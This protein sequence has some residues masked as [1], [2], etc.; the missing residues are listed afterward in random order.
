MRVFEEFREFEDTPPHETVSLEEQAAERDAQ[1]MFQMNGLQLSWVE[2]L[3]RNLS[4][5]QIV[6]QAEEIADHTI[7]KE[8]QKRI[9]E[10]NLDV[11]KEAIMGEIIDP[12]G[13]PL[14]GP[15]RQWFRV[16]FPHHRDGAI[17]PVYKQILKLYSENPEEAVRQL[18]TLY[19]A[20]LH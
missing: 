12:Q 4:D 7:S 8:L 13:S 18:D 10:G 6:S 16:V 5:E 1:E 20:S 17:G 3:L 14:G 11:K 19:R 2:Y 9:R 15:E